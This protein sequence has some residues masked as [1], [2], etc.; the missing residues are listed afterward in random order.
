MGVR[1]F[2][3]NSKHGVISLVRSKAVWS[4]HPNFPPRHDLLQVYCILYPTLSYVTSRWRSCFAEVVSRRRS[5]LRSTERRMRKRGGKAFK[6]NGE[7]YHR[8]NSANCFRSTGELRFF[9]FFLFHFFSFFCLFE[10]INCWECL[11][12]D[13]RRIKEG[14]AAEIVPP[15]ES[16]YRWYVFCRVNMERG[17]ISF[18]YVIFLFETK[19]IIGYERWIFTCGN[20]LLSRN[21]KRKEKIKEKF[22]RII[23]R[24]LFFVPA[25]Q[26]M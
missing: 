22:I 18:F 6:V 8:H 16:S 14:F 12:N 26:I 9:F 13:W 25:R 15:N 3:D 7:I 11:R 4:I 5:V 2:H 10:D 21:A 1:G 24:S 20:E 17:L 19:G 23:I